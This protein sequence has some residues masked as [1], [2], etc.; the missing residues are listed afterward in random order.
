MQLH[1]RNALEVG[2]LEEYGDPFHLRS[3]TL[4]RSSA[5]PITRGEALAASRAPVGL[6]LGWRR[7]GSL[8]V[9][10]MGAVTAVRP[11][12]RLKPCGR[13]RFISEHVGQLDEADTLAVRLAGC[14]DHDPIPLIQRHASNIEIDRRSVKYIIPFKRTWRCCHEPGPSVGISD[15]C[16]FSTICRPLSLVSPPRASACCRFSPAS[17]AIGLISNVALSAMQGA[18]ARVAK[19]RSFA[20]IVRDRQ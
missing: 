14:L 6:L 16:R 11:D 7:F 20:P 1:G 19:S 3:V 4:E 5:V 18:L 10:A 2:H 8:G 15:M 17:M 12:Q 9:A 13:R